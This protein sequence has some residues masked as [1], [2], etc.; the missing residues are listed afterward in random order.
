M[1]HAPQFPIYIISKGRAQSRFT[2]KTL[3][4]INVPFR[5]VVEEQERAEYAAVIDPARILVLDPEYQRRYDTFGR[6]GAHL[7]TG[8]GP[9]RN[10]VWD[11]AVTEGH[12]F[13]WLMDDNIR[14]F[15][16]LNRNVYGEVLDGTVLRCMEDFVLRY[17]NVALA[18]PNYFMFA[19][20]K[21][22]MPAFRLNTR[23]YSC[24]LIRNDI[25]FRWRGRYNEDTDLS[26]RV[27]KAGWCTVLFNAFLQHKE[28]TM[29]VKGGNTDTIY[30]EGTGAKSRMLAEMHPDVAEVVERWGRIHHF[31]DYTPFEK[32]HLI[33]KPGAAV[34]AGLNEYGME[35]IDGGKR[36]GSVPFSKRYAQAEP[37]PAKKKTAA[38]KTRTAAVPSAGA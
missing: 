34:P 9:A 8:S 25:P 2:V 28:V 10:F 38:R 29:R 11:H 26:L 36:R 22:K 33:L 12:A 3:N 5:I 24:L 4:K 27:L 14:Y 6:A 13:H 7:G 31:V 1:P 37:P 35:V 30:K 32:N 18:G 21:Q 17:E 16:R 15:Y 20:R 19:P 23:I